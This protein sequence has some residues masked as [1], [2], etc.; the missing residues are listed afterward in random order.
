M[1][2]P[3]LSRRSFRE[4]RETLDTLYAKNN[5]TGVVTCNTA[6]GKH[7]LELA[8]KGYDDS[9]QILPKECL[10]VPGFQRMVLRGQVTVTD[11]ESMES[12]MITMMGASTQAAPTVQYQNE[13]GT[14]Q[15]LTPQIDAPTANRDIVMKVDNDPNSRTFGQAETPKCL[16]GGEPV[17]QNAL[18][19][20]SG[21]PPL[22]ELHQGEAPRVV[23]QPLPD[24]TW[25]HRLGNP[26]TIEPVQ[27]LAD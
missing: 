7:S 10:N 14:Y 16:V 23:S 13:D 17:F 15:N 9:I 26:V 12:E 2:T 21:E 11:D 22:C 18:Q 27:R 4:L 24:G 5:T 8:P 20:K 6:D 19:I 1:T 25:H 3:A